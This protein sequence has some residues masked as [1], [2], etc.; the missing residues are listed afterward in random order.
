MNKK[1]L[2]VVGAWIALLI[3]AAA[4]DKKLFGALL[5]TLSIGLFAWSIVTLAES[6]EGD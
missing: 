5:A 2:M 4:I 6:S 1:T 3:A